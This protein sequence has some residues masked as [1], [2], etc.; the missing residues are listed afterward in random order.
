MTWMDVSC[1]LDQ[2]LVRNRSA[3]HLQDWIRKKVILTP[4]DQVL[5][6]WTSSPPDDDDD[7]LSV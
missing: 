1:N 5:R 6:V 4:T 3:T 7:F 2:N